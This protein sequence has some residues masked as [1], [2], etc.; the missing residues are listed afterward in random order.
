MKTLNIV[1]AYMR[2]PRFEIPLPERDALVVWTAVEEPGADVVVYSSG[3]SYDAKEA[4]K[5]P[6]A[7]RILYTYEPLVVWPR[8]FFRGFWQPFDVVLTWSEALAEQGGKF[9]RFPSL[10]YDFPFGAA[11]GVTKSIT[12]EH[13]RQNAIVQIAGSKRSFVRSELYSKRRQIARWFGRHGAL[14]LDT[15]GIPAMPVPNYCGRAADKLET[16]AK[17]R[18]ALCLENDGHPIWSRGYV[19]EKIFDCFYAGT[20]PVYLGAAD[21]EQHIPADCFIDLRRF[22]SFAELDSFLST[23]TDETFRAYQLAIEAFLKT[24]DAPAKHSCLRLYEGALDLAEAPPEKSNCEPF[25]F[26]QNA[27]WSEKARCTLMMGA[28]PLYK[29]LCGTRYAGT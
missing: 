2:E 4:A 1:Y 15:Y 29:K 9:V 16:L 24:Y 20:I 21:I 13:L 3:Y 14:E 10:Y 27:S 7:F 5:N 12:S 28:L 23:M 18:F 11:H 19:T 22:D 6:E 8:Q 26:W 25:G 17:Y